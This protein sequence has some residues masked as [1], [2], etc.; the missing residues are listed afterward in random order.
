MKIWNFRSR[1]ACTRCSLSKV[2]RSVTMQRKK[3]ND[4]DTTKKTPARKAAIAI[5]AAFV[6]RSA[7]VVVRFI[8]APLSLL[9]I[10]KI[11]AVAVHCARSDVTDLCKLQEV[12]NR[13][14]R[15]GRKLIHL[16]T[17]L[18]T[19]KILL[20]PTHCVNV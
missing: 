18:S 13:Q 2:Y 7:V 6:K 5:S 8:I 12:P 9:I 11:D 19:W 17:T 15:Q 20:F 16:W 10:T 3:P 1:G 4:E 14:T